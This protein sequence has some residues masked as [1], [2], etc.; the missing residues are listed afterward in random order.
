MKA[1][2]DTSSPF[3]FLFWLRHGLKHPTVTVAALFS[4]LAAS[5]RKQAEKSKAKTGAAAKRL[6]AGKGS[7]GSEHQSSGMFAFPLQT[8]LSERKQSGVRC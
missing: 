6:F 2:E 8:V 1:L 7:D 4:F 3:S 5:G